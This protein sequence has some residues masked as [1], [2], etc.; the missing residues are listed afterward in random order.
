MENIKSH[1]KK[2]IEANDNNRLVIF[3]GAGVSKSSDTKINKMPG[4][5]DII[6][7]L[8]KDL[9]GNVKGNDYLRIAQLYFLEFKADIYFK[10]IKAYFPNKFKPSSVHELIFDVLPI[11]QT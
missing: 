1:I 11:N 2:I 9:G 8:K 10:K 6:K 3:V 4:W 7:G 5:G